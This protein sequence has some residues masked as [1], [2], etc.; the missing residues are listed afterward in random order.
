M[1]HRTDT[2][3]FTFMEVMTA[4]LI[5]CIVMATLYKAYSSNVETVQSGRENSQT[6]QV[7]RIVFDLMKKDLESAF[8]TAANSVPKWRL[9]LIGK[10]RL[11]G[12]RKADGIDFTTASKFASLGDPVQTDLCEVGYFVE[13]EREGDGFILYR[14]EDLTLD[15]DFTEGGVVEELTRAVK[16][17][18]ILYEDSQGQEVSG[19]STTQGGAQ[20]VLPTLIKVRLTLESPSGREE[21]YRMSVHPELAWRKGESSAIR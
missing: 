8:M 20:G 4:V 2:R 6:R 7:V 15:T 21:T 3:G 5:L 16:V 18:E 1:S 17:F 19:W 14:R 10:S 13:Q 9:G 12:N 11:I